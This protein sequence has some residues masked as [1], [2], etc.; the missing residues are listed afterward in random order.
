M[1]GNVPGQV[2]LLETGEAP[3]GVGCG[4]GLLGLKAVQLEGHRAIAAGEFLRG[5]PQFIGARL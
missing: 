2:V 4:Q 1:P 5:Y 3:V